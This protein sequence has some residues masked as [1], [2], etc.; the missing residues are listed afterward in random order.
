MDSTAQQGYLFAD[1]S[2]YGNRLD[3]ELFDDFFFD[4]YC[5]TL[6][7]VWFLGEGGKTGDSVRAVSCIILFLWWVRGRG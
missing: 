2:D 6:L 7:C 1:W 4:C 3:S 5:A